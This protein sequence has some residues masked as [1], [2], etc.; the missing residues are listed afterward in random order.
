MSNME[1]KLWN[2][3]DGICTPDEQEAISKLIASDESYRLKYQELLA[4]NKEFAAIELD[5]PP[6]AFTY[7]VM[8]AVRNEYAQVTLKA[9]INKRIIMGI[10]I[11]FGVT[12]ATMLAY[13]GANINWSAGSGVTIPVDFKVPDL[14]KY[15]SKPVIESFVFFDVI[16]GLFLFDKYLHRRGFSKDKLKSV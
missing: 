8:E 9:A 16:L 6:M 15:I 13:A 1:E 10:A 5:E 3:I 7:N 12:I 4:L 11:F 14:S 2:Y